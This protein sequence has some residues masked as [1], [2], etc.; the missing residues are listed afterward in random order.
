VWIAPDLCAAVS[1]EFGG[2]L[3]SELPRYLG[4]SFYIPT[5]DDD[6]AY[7]ALDDGRSVPTPRVP[8]DRF[9][10]SLLG[11]MGGNADFMAYFKTPCVVPALPTEGYPTDAEIDQRFSQLVERL[12]A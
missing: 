12:A 11:D 7:C 3:D 1:P 9:K 2:T 4:P 5:A 8:F 6:M 10:S